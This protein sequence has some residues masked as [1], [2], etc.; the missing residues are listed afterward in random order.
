MIT[1]SIEGSEQ[2]TYMLRGIEQGINDLRPIWKDVDTIFRA[3]MRQIFQ[4][5]GAY[6]GSKWR[7]LNPAYAAR[8]ARQWGA[9]PILQASGALMSSFVSA[10]DADHVYRVGPTFGEFG[11]RKRYAKAHQYGFPPHKLPARPMLRKFT[12][13]EGERVVDV[14]LGHLFKQARFAGKRR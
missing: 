9:R 2:A 4:S 11:S 13:S 14:I 5:E 10:S 3:F 1:I 6:G 7:A 8:K 12:K